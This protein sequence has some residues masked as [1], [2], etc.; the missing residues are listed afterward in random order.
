MSASIFSAADASA[1]QRHAASCYAADELLRDTR[2]A[3]LPLQRQWQ[4]RCLML[5]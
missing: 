3:A 4:K 1:A 2:Y 5:L